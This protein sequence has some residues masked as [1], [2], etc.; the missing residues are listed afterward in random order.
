MHR[1]FRIV[2]SVVFLSGS[3]CA[4]EG[5][6]IKAPSLST[7]DV[8]A[9]LDAA[10]DGDTV[11]L[12]AGTVTWSDNVKLKEKAVTLRGAGMAQTVIIDGTPNDGKYPTDTRKPLLIVG[13]EGKPWRLTNMTF[14]GKAE[15]NPDNDVGIPHLVCIGGTCKNWRID[16]CAFV[17]TVC[18]LLVQGFTYGLIDHCEFRGTLKRD[19]GA[20]TAIRLEGTRKTDWSRPLSLG[21]AE[22]VYI[23]DCVFDMDQKSHNFNAIH[24][25]SG[26]RVVFRHCKSNAAIEV[27]GP[28]NQPWR[29]TVSFEI[30]D[31]VFGGGRSH[32]G[33]YI[34]V[35]LCGGTGVFFNNTV[36]SGI[37]SSNDSAIFLRCYRTMDPYTI[38]IPGLEPHVIKSK[39]DG[40]CIVDGNLPYD[41]AAT[42]KHSGGAK[43]ANLTCADGNWT[44]NRWVGFYIWNVTGQ[45]RGKI[46]A[47]TAN[48]VTATLEP[49]NVS[50]DKA[51]AFPEP[52]NARY[53]WDPGDVF[54]ITN[55][56][57]CLD[58]IGR[59]PGTEEVFGF[60]VQKSE[61]IY[62]W[63]NLL[64][65]KTK[66]HFALRDP[67]VS[68]EYLKEGR[69]FI[70]D[71]PRPGYKPFQYP[72]PLQNNGE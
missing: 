50:G 48:T 64:D 35:I 5:N 37:F 72:H 53:S 68:R 24:T 15:G 39:G 58:Q 27:F 70:N 3:T 67:E 40:S 17:E 6:V 60:T 28:G 56:Y 18:G 61:P 31:N 66:L 34:P 29:G 20:V 57:P 21:S 26:A 46:T 10:K 33:A 2:C 1:F 43:E 12:P 41:A 22:A 13:A 16:H 71:T 30:Y 62:E 45:S 49:V 44:P 32:G 9:A 23:E 14:R 8:Q 42:G 65:G 19:G 11:Q 51:I 4:A 25:D 7:A 63:N 52:K 38:S 55:G 47:N 69:D 36:Q 59:G 54:K